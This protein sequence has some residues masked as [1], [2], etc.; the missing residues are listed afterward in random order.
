M[1]EKTNKS[2][3]SSIH[4]SHY[5][6][7]ISTTLLDQVNYKFFLQTLSQH[8]EQRVLKIRSNNKAIKPNHVTI[9]PLD[10]LDQEPQACLSK[11]QL[12]PERFES[13]PC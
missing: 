4:K 11:H 12:I 1:R 5:T 6:S 2:L 8:L 7:L 3:R 13:L 9:L 10:D